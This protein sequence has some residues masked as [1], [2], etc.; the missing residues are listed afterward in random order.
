ML[1]RTNARGN[2][3]VQRGADATLT[4]GHGRN[5]VLRSACSHGHAHVVRK[6]K[7]LPSVCVPACLPVF[8]MMCG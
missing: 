4:Y 6:Q 5:T 3:H 7:Q 2:V 1:T 8:V